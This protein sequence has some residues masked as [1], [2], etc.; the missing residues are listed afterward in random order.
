MKSALPVLLCTIAAGAAE[1]RWDC[2][3]TSAQ[4]APP[5]RIV[6][7]IT[8]SQEEPHV[9]A[10][11]RLERLQRE[12]DWRSLTAVY[13]RLG[14]LYLELGRSEDAARVYAA[15]FDLEGPSTAI[16]ENFRSALAVAIYRQHRFDDVIALF[17]RADRP[18]CPYSKSLAQLVLA[19][20]YAVRDRL[21]KAEAIAATHLATEDDTF[22]SDLW[23]QLRMELACNRADTQ[24]CVA[25]WDRLLRNPYR[26]ETLTAVLAKQ[27]ERLAAWPEGKAMLAAAGNDGLIK[28]GKLEPS[29]VRHV[30]D[31]VAVSQS[32]PTYP[33]DAARRRIE[34]T[35]Q[36]RL[37][38]GTDGSV[39]SARVVDSI[40]AGVFDKAALDA[41]RKWKFS[42]ATVDGSPV[43]ADT[44]KSIDFRME[45]S[46]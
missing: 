5:Y 4:V 35:V 13:E 32:A 10:V 33:P 15:G 17:E 22:E 1:A 37:I 11:Q 9:D 44:N 34:G 6:R 30:R 41:V 12:K 16:R 21:D 38:V 42:P 19:Y 18:A 24:T 25:L 46:R 27:L 20:S 31:L 29:G 8:A 2:G 45:P 28:G 40:P 43:V 36:L 39:Q 23:H 26:G 7:A 14:E 3:E